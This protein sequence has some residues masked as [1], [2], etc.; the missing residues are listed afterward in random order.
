MKTLF[1]SVLLAATALTV[2]ANEN[3]KELK[4]TKRSLQAKINFSD[5]SKKLK[6]NQELSAL[7]AQIEAATLAYQNKKR[8]LLEKSDPTLVE[9]FKKLDEIN[10]KL[11]TSK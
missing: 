11:K 10:T 5:A 7:K 8:S 2:S 3:T 1:V 6:N 4:K 9:L